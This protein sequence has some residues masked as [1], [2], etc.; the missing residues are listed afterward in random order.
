MNISFVFTYSAI[1]EAWFAFS[2]SLLSARGR[3][4]WP[5]WARNLPLRVNFRI[6][7]SPGPVAVNHTLSLWSTNTLCMPVGC[8]P[9]VGSGLG[10]PLVG[11]SYSC[12]GLGPPHA[13]TTLPA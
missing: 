8:A 9:A 1:P 12:V 13:W 4:V 6:W 7:P 11:Q 3:F 10:P 2:M 5:Y